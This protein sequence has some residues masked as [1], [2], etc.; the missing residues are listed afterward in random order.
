MKNLKMPG[1]APEQQMIPGNSQ[2]LCPNSITFTFF[3]ESKAK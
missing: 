2:K 1:N 3:K